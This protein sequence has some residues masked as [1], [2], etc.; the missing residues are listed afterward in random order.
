MPASAVR[1]RAVPNVPDASLRFAGRG[2]V[3]GSVEL[4]LHQPQGRSRYQAT[5]FN[6]PLS[7]PRF[8]NSSVH[9]SFLIGPR[10]QIQDRCRF[11]DNAVERIQAPS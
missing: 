5:A 7:R 10:P 2:A 4:R 8:L 3:N 1:D 11:G 9:H 6:I